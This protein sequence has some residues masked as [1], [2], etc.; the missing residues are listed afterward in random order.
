MREVPS[1]SGAGS[2]SRV[3]HEQHA[4]CASG[5]G[6]ERPSSPSHTAGRTSALGWSSD[7]ARRPMGSGRETPH[8][9][10]V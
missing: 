10:V 8:W 6:R 4:G 2:R 7:R 3:N 5:Q 9:R 1:S